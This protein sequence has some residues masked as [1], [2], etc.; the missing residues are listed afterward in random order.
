MLVKVAWSKHFAVG[1]RTHANAAS[2]GTHWKIKVQTQDIVNRVVK[3]AECKR[4]SC[5]AHSSHCPLGK[6]QTGV[7]PTLRED[8]YT[9]IPLLLDEPQQEEPDGDLHQADAD[10]QQ[11]PVDILPAEKGRKQ[12]GVE[13][14]YMPAGA[15]LALADEADHGS[16]G[17]YL[18]ISP[19]TYQQ[20]QSWYDAN[21]WVPRSIFFFCFFFLILTQG[22]DL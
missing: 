5:L 16:N 10:Y 18:F 21:G 12:R 4:V 20:T 8:Y 14:P 3:T 19:E 15:R 17:G 2:G 1:G 9:T 11:N 7:N 6:H 13:V 22:V